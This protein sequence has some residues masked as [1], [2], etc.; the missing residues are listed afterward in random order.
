MFDVTLTITSVNGCSNSAVYIDYVTVVEPPVANFTYLI[1]DN[2]EM[3]NRVAFNNTSDYATHYEWS[4]GDG[5]SN[6]TD[7]NPIHEYPTTTTR[8]YEVLLTATNDYGCTSSKLQIIRINEKLLFFIP[9]AFTPDG[10]DFNEEFRP[11]FVSGL[12]V[13]DYHLIIFNRW[14]EMV[15]ESYD[16]NYGWGWFVRLCRNSGGWKLCLDNFFR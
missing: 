15:F 2:S 16:A 13:Y 14:G 4:F 8:S 3:T 7:E 1:D 11:I 10:D 6:S 12:D 9:N 5:S